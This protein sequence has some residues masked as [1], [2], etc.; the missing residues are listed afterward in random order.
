MQMEK[1]SIQKKQAEEKNVKEKTNLGKDR[2]DR[3]KKGGTAEK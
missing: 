3:Q 2:N 1:A